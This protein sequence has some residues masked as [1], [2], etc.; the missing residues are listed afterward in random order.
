MNEFKEFTLNTDG[1]AR[2]NPGPS[3]I[4]YV[5]KT[6]DTVVKE[7]GKY[8]GT[9]TNNE[10]EYQALILG[11]ENAV[12]LNVKKLKCLL[13]SELVVKQLNGQYKVKIPR[14]KVFFDKIKGIEPKFAVISYYH[15]PRSLNS[16]ADALVNKVLDENQ[17]EERSQRI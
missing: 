1:G 3:G 6:S 7:E 11:L 2:G 4:A 14:L 15:V 13:D 16:E 5:L 8:I 9:A 17:Y 10:A 12:N